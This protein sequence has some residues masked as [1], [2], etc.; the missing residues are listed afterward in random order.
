M[1]KWLGKMTAVICILAVTAM[2]MMAI[3]THMI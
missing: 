3:V 2:A 1:L